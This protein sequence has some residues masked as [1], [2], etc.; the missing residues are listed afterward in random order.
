[1]A[2]SAAEE[3]KQSKQAEQEGDHQA[4]IFSGSAPPDQSLGAGR[5]FGEG[6]PTDQPLAAGRGFGEGQYALLAEDRPGSDKAVQKHESPL[7]RARAVLA[8]SGP[9]RQLVLATTRLRRRVGWR[10]LRA[11]LDAM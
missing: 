8:L 4:E 3:G 6:Q 7:A 10:V 1:M 5:S 9:H 2:V 11:Y